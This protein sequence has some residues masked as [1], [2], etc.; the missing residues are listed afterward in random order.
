[1]IT[2]HSS[3]LCRN[4]TDRVPLRNCSGIDVLLHD[5]E[6]FIITS[7]HWT[8]SVRN[9]T[10]VLLNLKKEYVLRYNL[11]F[12]LSYSYVN[13]IFVKRGIRF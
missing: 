12:V 13:E 9:L 7:G 10:I 6:I 8:A 5:F 1:M 2:L 4:I 11:T 3:Y